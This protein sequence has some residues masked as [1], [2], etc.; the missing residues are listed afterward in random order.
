M[1]YIEEVQSNFEFIQ[2]WLLMHKY[3]YYVEDNSQIN[4]QHYDG[5]EEYSRRVAKELGFRA[6][7]Q[8]GPEENEKHHVHWMVDFNSNSPYW[9]QC[10]KKYKRLLPKSA[11]K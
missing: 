3:W 7:K 1:S 9:E 6:D 11:F 5:A 2:L 10:K 4:D 8:L